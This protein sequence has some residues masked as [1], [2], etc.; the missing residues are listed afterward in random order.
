MMGQPLYLMMLSIKQERPLLLFS[1]GLIISAGGL[2]VGTLNCTGTDTLDAVLGVLVCGADASGGGGVWT[3]QGTYLDPTNG[4]GI[5]VHNAS[6]TFDNLILNNATTT[7]K[8][9][10]GDGA[11][12]SIIRWLLGNVVTWLMG[13]DDS[14][15]DNYVISAGTAIGTNNVLVASTSAAY[16]EAVH[17]PLGASKEG[18]FFA[19][20]SAEIA[21]ATSYTL[22]DNDTVAITDATYYSES[23]GTIT[24]QRTGYYK[25]TIRC[26]A[27]LD[28]GTREF[29]ECAAS[30][31]GTEIEYS[32][33]GMYVREA[34]NIGTGCTSSIIILLAKDDTIS[35]EGRAD[36]TSVDWGGALTNPT[37]ILIEFI[38]TP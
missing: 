26:N 25:I 12:D 8:H 11:G 3:D 2:K 15:N 1:G 38:K 19:Y 29:A 17:F 20:S 14:D 28:S 9:T 31:G 36:T 10:F 16:T 34:G 27:D 21:G 18:Y 24:I 23:A 7:E 30:K 4:E 13:L 6:S 33:C 5:L 37:S 32:K 35:L 22:L